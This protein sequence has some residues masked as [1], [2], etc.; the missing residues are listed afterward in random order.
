M[1]LSDALKAHYTYRSQSRRSPTVKR[2]WCILT[3]NTSLKG[4]SAGIVSTTDVLTAR[5]RTSSLPPDIDL[6][7]YLLANLLLGQTEESLHRRSFL[8]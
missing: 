1:S 5:D 8:F 6:A 2:P 7:L 4:S 3:F